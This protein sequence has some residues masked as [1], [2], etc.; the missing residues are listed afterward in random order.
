VNGGNAIALWI[1]PDAPA[2]ELFE[3]ADGSRIFVPDDLVDEVADR[4]APGSVRAAGLAPHAAATA[5][6]TL[7]PKAPREV[8]VRYAADRV[9]RQLLIWN[10]TS[11]ATLYRLGVVG[12]S[13]GEVCLVRRTDRLLPRQ[14]VRATAPRRRARAPARPGRADSERPLGPLTAAGSGAFLLEGVR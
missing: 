8:I 6:L 2:G 4:A 3:C 5:V 10:V 14:R 7:G 9:R 11:P 1:D 12:M 13:V